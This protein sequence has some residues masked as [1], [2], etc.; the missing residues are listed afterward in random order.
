MKK[1]LALIMVAA[2]VPTLFIGCKARERVAESS[3]EHETIVMNAP[4]GN[5]SYFVDEVH[6]RFPEINLEIIPYNGENAT[7][8]A[9]DMFKADE[10][11][12]VYFT[13]Y[14]NCRREDVSDKC[15]DLS[16]YDFLDNYVD[17]R[18]SDVTDH[19][20]V[21]MLPMAY[22]CLGITYNKTLLDKNGWEL[23]ESLEELEEL[24]PKIKAAGCK[25]ALT[26]LQYP[27][28]GFQYFCSILSTG[29]LS[30]I[31]GIEWQEDFL[32]GDTT[33][34]DTP[35]MVE[36]AKLLERWRKDGLLNTDGDI[37]DDHGTINEMAKGNTLFLLGNSNDI[38]QTSEVNTLD[39]FRVMPYLSVDGSQNVYMLNVSRYVALN[40]KLGESG[41]EQK[42]EDAIHILEVIS[43]VEGMNSLRPQSENSVIYPLK[44]ATVNGNSYYANVLDDINAGH[45]ASFIYGGWENFVAPVGGKIASY[46]KGECSLDDVIKFWDEKQSAVTEDDV[47]TYTKV[48]QTLDV[49]DC[50]KIVGI[51]FAK[52]TGADMSLISENK[53]IYNTQTDSMNK[54]GVSGSLFS[55]PVRDEEMVT[56]LPTGWKGTIETV[57]LSGA[58]IKEL[59]KE[60]YDRD[61]NGRTYPYQLVTKEGS[62]IED[63]KIYKVA[64]CG[65]TDAVKEEGNIKD[66]GVLGLDAAKEYLSTFE[67]LSKKDIVWE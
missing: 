49:S 15:L 16:G 61:C 57:T 27:G 7:A 32:N 19:G 54:E 53:W 67:T 26:Q 17:A 8:Y 51:S 60:G 36:A 10:M 39:E 6:R 33:L 58:R 45:T 37:N 21:Y 28:F 18:L 24:I 23:P 46:I 43:T 56:I 38:A 63:N 42:L 41:N 40:K 9:S 13:T 35:E 31:Q 55:L 2:M 1:I 44:D 3:N 48:T 25:L 66:S 30:T 14:Y 50:A 47:I 20:A 29:Y 64:I 11:P 12:D 62:W 34:A 59:V 52:A 22:N 65:A 4:Y 5:M